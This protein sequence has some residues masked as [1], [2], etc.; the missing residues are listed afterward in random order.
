MSEFIT[1]SRHLGSS[2]QE[3][4]DVHPAFRDGFHQTQI[5]LDLPGIHQSIYLF[6]DLLFI[7]LFVYLLVCLFILLLVWQADLFR[8]P[9]ALELCKLH[10][11]QVEEGEASW[12]G[13]P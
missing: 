6:I 1:A 7:C 13:P 11:N 8:M 9:A 5:Y 12:P 2:C 10:G 4:G 3:A